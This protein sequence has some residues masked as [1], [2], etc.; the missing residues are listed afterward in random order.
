MRRFVFLL[1]IIPLTL[2]SAGG[3][4]GWS[5]VYFQMLLSSYCSI[6][7]NP[8]LQ[9]QRTHHVEIEFKADC[10]SLR[11]RGPLASTPFEASWFHAYSISTVLGAG[12]CLFMAFRKNPPNLPIRNNARNGGYRASV[13]ALL[14]L[15]VLAP[16][17]ILTNRTSNFL[18]S[19][20]APIFEC[21]S[22][23]S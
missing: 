20:I 5:M 18:S 17:L 19:G 22:L 21:H 23:I 1:L 8:S 11:D 14:L 10:I 16:L 4:T 15:S 7:P 6:L 9:I 13:I 3:C 12:E 2:S